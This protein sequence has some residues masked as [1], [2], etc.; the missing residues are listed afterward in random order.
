MF[1]LSRVPRRPTSKQKVESTSKGTKP[2]AVVPSST[3]SKTKKRVLGIP[4]PSFREPDDDELA[5]AEKEFLEEYDKGKQHAN[6]KSRKE[7]N[8]SSSQSVPVSAKKVNCSGKQQQQQK[9]SN[10]NTLLLSSDEEDKDD[11]SVLEMKPLT[12]KNAKEN[13]GKPNKRLKSLDSE[14]TEPTDT[15]RTRDAG[16]P[17]QQVAGLIEKGSKSSPIETTLD[18]ATKCRIDEILASSDFDKISLKE[19]YKLLGKEVVCKGRKQII[20]DYIC[21][22]LVLP[23]SH[24]D[25]LTVSNT[26]PCTSTTNHD[27]SDQVPSQNP[28]R[29]NIH[30][31]NHL[32]CH[33]VASKSSKEPNPDKSN[34]S[35]DPQDGSERMQEED[36]KVV[37]RSQTLENSASKDQPQEK[38]STAPPPSVSNNQGEKRK[39]EPDNVADNV[40]VEPKPKKRKR[41]PKSK[42]IDN[43]DSTDTL[44][45]VPPPPKTPPPPAKSARKRKRAPTKRACQLCVQCPCRLEKDSEEV[46]TLNTSQSDQAMEKSLIKRLQKCEKTAE[47]YV[48]QE[49]VVRRQLKNHRRDMWRKREA[50]QEMARQSRKQSLPKQ[51]HFLPDAKEIEENFARAVVGKSRTKEDASKARN[52]LFGPKKSYQITLTQM[53]GGDDGS[54]CEENAKEEMKDDKIVEGCDSDKVSDSGKPPMEGNPV[55]ETDDLPEGEPVSCERIEWVDGHPQGD[56][57]QEIVAVPSTLWS[58]AM[59]GRPHSTFD[60]L[61]DDPASTENLGMEDLLEMLDEADTQVSGNFVLSESPDVTFD[62]LSQR[63]RDYAS[64][65]MEHL[66]NDND[67]LEMVNSVNPNWEENVRFAFSLRDNEQISKALSA[68]REEKNRLERAR[69]Q[70]ERLF[71]RHSS[72]LL[73]FEETLTSSLGRL[74]PEDDDVDMTTESNGPFSQVLAQT[75]DDSALPDDGHENNPDPTDHDTGNGDLEC[76]RFE[77]ADISYAEKENQEN[78]FSTIVGGHEVPPLPAEAA[79]WDEGMHSIATEEE[80]LIPTA[81]PRR[82]SIS[83]CRS[84]SPRRK[85]FVHVPSTLLPSQ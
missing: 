44:S 14:K 79:I 7:N 38:Q 5:R 63:G 85:A 57:G 66:R 20:R 74:E 65:I 67:R 50:L 27:E 47:R 59:T 60:R 2:S 29:N 6:K 64:T 8:V 80:T 73:F 75:N 56:N 30:V 4:I 12:H 11:D 72:A 54:D 31:L 15:N 3:K 84:P 71:T 13:K 42:K 23:K 46:L 70:L 9:S 25:S 43:K 33:H 39:E 53:M 21:Q 28:S 51:S 69:V 37:N 76:S 32:P 40:P 22:K 61:F 45:S 41:A 83:T 26:K 24:P 10:V 58:C 49:E 16:P 77:K 1:S 81:T 62:D 68:V 55:D 34:A 52:S 36:L 78:E 17:S 35:E 18:D 48:H 19:V 82:S